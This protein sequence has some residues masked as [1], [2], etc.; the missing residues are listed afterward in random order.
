MNAQIE[1]I[2]PGPWVAPSAG[3]WTADGSMMVA[4][5]GG[6]E[7]TKSR[8]R[9]GRT[10]VRADARLIAAAP[11]LLEALRVV[12]ADW[13]EQFERNGHLAPSWCRQARAAISKA[14]TP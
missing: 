13:T 14:V 2:T 5:L 6:R 9:A 11:E 7:V 1:K 3:V 10:D 4:D 12:V 8:K